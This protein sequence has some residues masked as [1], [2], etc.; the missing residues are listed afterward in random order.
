LLDAQDVVTDVDACAVL[1]PKLGSDVE[2]LIVEGAVHDLAL[3]AEEPR[4][5]FFEAMFAWLEKELP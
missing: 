5:V 2:S 4:A 1:A 3:S